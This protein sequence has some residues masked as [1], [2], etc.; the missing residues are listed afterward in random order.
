MLG[1]SAITLIDM[2]VLAVVTALLVLIVVLIIV[3][4]VVVIFVLFVIIVLILIAVVVH[5]LIFE[6]AARTFSIE[7]LLAFLLAHLPLVVVLVEVKAEQH[8]AQ[9]QLAGRVLLLGQHQLELH[10]VFVELAVI[11]EHLLH[12]LSRVGH[13]MAE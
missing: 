9:V 13:I 5:L 7:C 10:Q 6:L 3:L 2:R 11:G 8:V 4:P 1:A 12:D